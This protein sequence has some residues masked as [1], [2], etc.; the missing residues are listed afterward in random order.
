M[1]AACPRTEH[2]KNTPLDHLPCNTVG[3]RGVVPQV[4]QLAV[5]DVHAANAHVVLRHSIAGLIRVRHLLSEK[6]KPGKKNVFFFP[7]RTGAR[8]GTPPIKKKLMYVKYKS[9][10]GS[11]TPSSMLAKNMPGIYPVVYIEF[12]GFLCNF[13]IS[14]LR[15]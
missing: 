6:K 14:Q 2:T 15:C 12:R 7:I 1:H 9:I 11:I 8:K 3:L 4:A 10:Q 13:S 5:D